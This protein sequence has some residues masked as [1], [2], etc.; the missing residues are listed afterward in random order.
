MND[1]VRVEVKDGI[2][3]VRLCRPDKRNAV[4]QPMF[5]GLIQAG[6][7]ERAQQIAIRQRYQRDKYAPW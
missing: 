7:E 3:D 5:R 4:D 6:P 1:R 2:A